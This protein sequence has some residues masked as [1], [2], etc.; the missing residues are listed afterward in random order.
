MNIALWSVQVLLVV[1]FVFSAAIKGTQSRQRAVELG[2]TGV[3]AVPLSLMRFVAAC[4]ALGSV[5]L[6]VP[7][8]T[9]IAPILTP[10][11][12]IGLGVIMVPAAR[13]HIG[14]GEPA[15]AVGNVVILAA[16]VFVAIGRWP[17]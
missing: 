6:V 16:C 7:Y 14:L 2:M 8:A 4:E 10:L 9:G 11:A 15:T 17:A 13:I 1:V 3:A 12:A 5:G